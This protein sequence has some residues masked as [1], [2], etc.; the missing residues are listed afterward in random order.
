MLLLMA[1]V[2]WDIKEIM[3]QHNVYVDVLLKVMCGAEC[4]LCE[5][6]S[7]LSYFLTARTHVFIFRHKEKGRGQV[8]AP[9]LK[10]IFNWAKKKQNHVLAPVIIH[11]KIHLHSSL[12][13][14]ESSRRC[15]V[16]KQERFFFFFSPTSIETG[17]LV[18]VHKMLNLFSLF[19]FCL[20]E[21]FGCRFNWILAN[22]YEQNWVFLWL[23]YFEVSALRKYFRKIMWKCF[24][25]GW[26]LT[27]PW[28]SS[29]IDHF[30]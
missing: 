22:S 26:V 9:F 1:G 20:Q 29:Y 6:M 18:L 14:S 16:W 30:G 5:L 27:F 7:T 10:G 2:K 11:C 19:L 23:I 8:K 28:L 17:L 4:V 15:H 3:S 13:W 12:L 21:P 25:L 24:Y